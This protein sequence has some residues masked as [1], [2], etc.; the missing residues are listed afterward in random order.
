MVREGLWESHKSDV[1][2]EARIT[3]FPRMV[4][5][6]YHTHTELDGDGY[7]ALIGSTLVDHG[8]SNL[9]YLQLVSAHPPTMHCNSLHHHCPH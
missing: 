9:T 7:P 6:L 5:E 8:D 3:D 1:D 2:V 4:Q